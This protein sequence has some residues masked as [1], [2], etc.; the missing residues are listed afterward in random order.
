MIA[1]PDGVVALTTGFSGASTFGAMT[2]GAIQDDL[3]ARPHPLMGEA[4]GAVVSVAHDR[5]SPSTAARESTD[6]FALARRGDEVGVAVIRARPS[7]DCCSSPCGRG[8]ASSRR[9]PVGGRRADPGVR[10][11]TGP[12]RG[13]APAH[14]PSF[15]PD[16]GTPERSE[17]PD[18]TITLDVSPTAV[19]LRAYTRL[20][21]DSL[22][23]VTAGAD[24]VLVGATL[25]E[26]TL[27]PA[28]CAP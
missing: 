25:T 5:P 4:P 22:L 19:C 8:R 26:T 28:R 10:G 23:S 13:E 1:S 14:G 11:T 16:A 18:G 27:T 12:K 17:V 3:R 9:A 7:D 21:D 15:D 20:T 6:T 24:G 2:F